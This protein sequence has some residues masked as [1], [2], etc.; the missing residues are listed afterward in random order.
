MGSSPQP[1][2]GERRLP[3]ALAVLVAGGLYL[4][5]PADF[6]ISEATHYAYPV[7]LIAFLVILLLVALVV[8]RAVNVR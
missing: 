2:R 8:A 5:I 6:R 4:F 1:R 3:M 7:V